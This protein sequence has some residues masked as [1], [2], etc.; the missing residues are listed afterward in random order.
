VTY[1]PASPGRWFRRWHPG[2]VHTDL[3]QAGLLRDPYLDLNEALVQWVG[4]AD[5]RYETT[6]PGFGAHPRLPG[7][8]L[9]VEFG[10][11]GGYR[12]RRQDGRAVRIP[13]CDGPGSC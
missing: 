11:E 13:I 9:A 10:E 5:W 1:P 6:F 3:L 8:G 4:R 12:T 2:C 7:M